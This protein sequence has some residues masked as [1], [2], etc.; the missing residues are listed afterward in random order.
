[1]LAPGRSRVIRYVSREDGI[2]ELQR[3]MA[4][5]ER[6]YELSSE[7]MLAALRRGDRID[8][9]EIARWMVYYQALRHL[10]R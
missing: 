10:G 3:M 7:E 6:R 8:T 9:A 1:M 4:E 5:Y 2:Q